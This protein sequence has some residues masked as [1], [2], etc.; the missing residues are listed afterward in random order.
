MIDHQ[1]NKPSDAL[2]LAPP[3]RASKLLAQ[4]GRLV[5]WVWG[6]RALQPDLSCYLQQV[7]LL[8]CWRL[9]RFHSENKNFYLSWECDCHTV[10]TMTLKKGQGVWKIRHWAFSVDFFA[11]VKRDGFLWESVRQHVRCW[12]DMARILVS[13][14]SLLFRC[15]GMSRRSSCVVMWVA[16]CSIW[17]EEDLRE[18]MRLK[19]CCMIRGCH[20][21]VS[22]KSW[23]AMRSLCHRGSRWRHSKKIHGGTVLC[24]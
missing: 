2:D 9:A 22:S 18:S 15:T 24:G 11:W 8:S 5:A 3:V 7:P 4:L 12:A 14:L 6:Q 21:E 17:C 13:P 19:S 23:K 10:Y 16:W 20:R 1:E